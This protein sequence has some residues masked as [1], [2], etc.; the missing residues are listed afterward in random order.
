MGQTSTSNYIYQE[1]FNSKGN[2]PT[3]NNDNRELTVRSG[4]YYFSHKREEKSW[5]RYLQLNFNLKTYK[6]FELETSIQ[7]ISGVDN[8]G[9]TFMYDFKDANNYREL[10]NTTSGYFRV[11]ESVNGTYTN[12]KGWTESSNVK[13]GNLCYK[14]FKSI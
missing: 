10:G 14:Y 6:D 13:K 4:K 3:G 1:E 5:E 2:W 9:V 8:F 11:A 12:I 7:K